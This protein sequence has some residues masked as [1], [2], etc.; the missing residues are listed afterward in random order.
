MTPGATKEKQ[1]IAATRVHASEDGPQWSVHRPRYISVSDEYPDK[2]Q[3]RRKGA[4]LVY[5]PHYS[6]SLRGNQGKNLKYHIH[7]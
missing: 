6:L 2:K 7:D 5:T 4:Y 1:G 3:L